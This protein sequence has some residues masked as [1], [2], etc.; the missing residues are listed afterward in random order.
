MV[1][2]LSFIL[3]I[4]LYILSCVYSHRDDFKSKSKLK[5]RKSA[6]INTIWKKN[7]ISIKHN[8]QCI[9]SW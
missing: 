3:W 9:I 8:R 5:S 2:I 4:D 6:F 7:F 1:V